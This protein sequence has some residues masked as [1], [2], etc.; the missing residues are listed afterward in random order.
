MFLFGGVDRSV[1]EGHIPSTIPEM[2]DL[3]NIDQG[4]MALEQSESSKLFGNNNSQAEWSYP[5]AF[6]ASDGNI[7][8]ISYNKV[9]VMDLS[10]NYRLTVTGEIP[11]VKSGISKIQKHKNLNFENN[12][13]ENLKLLTIGSAVGDTNSV[14][15]ISKDKVL[16]FGGK[17]VGKEYSP[18]NKVFS[19]DF[20]DTFNPQIK[21]LNSMRFARSN[22]NATIMPD[23]NIFINGGH[24][25][26]DLE[27][28]VFTPE[29]YN[30][31]TQTSYE[32]DKS[33]S[34][35]NYHATSLLL[36]DG[37]IL[38]AGGDVWNAEIFYPPYLFTKDINDNTVLAKRPEIINVNKKLERGK[39]E[40]IKVKGNVSKVTLVSTGSTT[41]A[42]NSESKFRDL[43]FT[44][45]SENEIEIQLDNNPNNLQN[46][47]YLLFVLNSNGTPSKGKIVFVN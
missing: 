15:M 22:A 8:G 29:I 4:W 43:D 5:R 1:T 39:S 45:V 42:Q 13:I 40:N 32:L 21:E 28:S 7:V 33:Y 47:N 19:I 31:N 23:G 14:V 6:L 3:K 24:S 34:R 36:P 11:L 10:N 41:H 16:V 37:R 25:Y 18:S 26:N 12:K 35:R 38:T 44:I 17:Q 9:W 46:G 27:F 30:P 2:I 20:S